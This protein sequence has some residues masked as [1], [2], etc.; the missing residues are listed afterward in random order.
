VAEGFVEVPGGRVFYRSVG[1]GSVP[2]LCLHGGPGFPHDYL[3]AL[4]GLADR[5]QVIFYDQLGCGRSDRPDD[6]SLWTVE[7][8]V[9][10]LMAVRTTLELDQ[11][12]LFGSS[13]GGM[14]AMEYVLREEQPKLESLILCSSPASIPR[15]IEGCNELVAQLPQETQETIRDHEARGMTACPEYTAAVLE[16]EKRHVCRLNRWP[17]GVERAYRDAGYN[18]YNYMNGP[19]EFTVVGT[20]KEWSVLDRLDEIEV[21]T[22]ITSG[23][24]DEARP[25]H[26][27]E[28][29]ERIAGSQLEILPGCSHLSFAEDP[30]AYFAIANA[31]FDRVEAA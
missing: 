5:R 31:F 10:E 17:E 6:D 21:P 19:S 11:L 18:V 22:L 20:L 9:E 25:D 28:I 3:E 30:D 12:H 23:E 24:H 16:F 27:H 13:W 8:F 29:H 4:E 2:L 15:W 1:E 7:R 26:M 14:L